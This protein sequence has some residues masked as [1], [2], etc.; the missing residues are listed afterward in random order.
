VPALDFRACT[1][2]RMHTRLFAAMVSRMQRL[3]RNTPVL[4]PAQWL[5]PQLRGQESKCPAPPRLHFFYLSDVPI[6]YHPRLVCTAEN[7]AMPQKWIYHGPF[8]CY[9]SRC[10]I[11]SSWLR[12]LARP[13]MRPAG[14]LLI[15]LALCMAFW[16]R[17]GCAEMIWS[18]DLAGSAQLRN[19]TTQGSSLVSAG[20]HPSQCSRPCH[21]AAGW[22]EC[23][24]RCGH[25]VAAA[26]ECRSGGA[27]RGLQ[28]LCSRKPTCTRCVWD[29]MG[30]QWTYARTHP[31]AQLACGACAHK[32]RASRTHVLA[33]NYT[34][35]TRMHS[36]AHTA[37]ACSAQA[38]VPRP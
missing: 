17:A 1:H 21:Q 11:G 29:W 35:H 7:S 5:A 26:V 19:L 15:W 32:H 13:L 23:H 28:Q 36:Y 38:H 6:G 30:G 20:A 14:C 33:H 16:V 27:W 8:V 18:D 25:H 22:C 3:H 9:P 2:A 34:P 37:I 10:T 4:T 12:T 24:G 31:R